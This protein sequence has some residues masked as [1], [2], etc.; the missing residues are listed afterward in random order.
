MR[1]AIFNRR[2]TLRLVVAVATVLAALS[3]DD[4]PVDDN[5]EDT[6]PITVTEI[7]AQPK[8]PSPGDTV[9]FT[10]VVT[11]PSQNVGDFPRLS[12]SADAGAFLET[13]QLS[14]RWVAPAQTN[15]Y[16][17]SVVATNNQN[18]S[19]RETQLFVGQTTEL[20][21]SGGGMVRLQPDG[22]SFVYVETTQGASNGQIYNYTGG[23]SSKATG[24]P[25]SGAPYV[26]A[27]DLSAAA[28]SAIVPVPGA[29]GLLSIE[30]FFEE[31]VAGTW[32][33]LTLDDRP[34]NIRRRNENT[35]PLFSPDSQL[36][37]WSAFRPGPIASEPDTFD[38]EVFTRQTQQSER[39]TLTHG[40]IRHN[41]F[42]TFSSDQKWLFFIS[43]RTRGSQWDFYALPVTGTTVATDSAATVKMTATGGLM[44]TGT[45]VALSRPLMLWNGNAATPIMAHF[46][47]AGDAIVRF[48]KPHATGAD[49]VEV[50]GVP[51]GVQEFSWSDDGSLLAASVSDAIY[52]ITPDGNGTLARQSLPGDG[53]RDI[54]WTMDKEWLVYRVTRSTLSWFE[55]FDYAAGRLEEPIVFASTFVS[56]NVSA[57]RRGMSMTAEINSAS[58][59]YAPMFP[60]G[61]MTPA[62]HSIDLSG[63]LQ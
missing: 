61:Q 59:F 2:N 48:I 19:S 13:N 14:V 29:V 47:N 1:I 15:I 56:G 53:L 6:G 35:I 31:I 49:I 21:P 10:A 37:A 24:N 32:Q 33:R 18:S 51:P 34:T 43:D 17:V 39:V 11:G 36:L 62:I 26:L 7:I 38:I 9:V 5:M 42:P 25:G 12:W 58:V 30:V 46:N 16:K 45:T 28:Y 20:V 52:V 55:L 57:Y 50:S 4:N 23:V 41:Y 40:R 3:C 44:A 63:I 54:I 22:V 27:H 60:V 8:S